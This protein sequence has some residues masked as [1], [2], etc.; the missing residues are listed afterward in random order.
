MLSCE[1]IDLYSHFRMDRKDAAGGRLFC[2]VWHTSDQ[3]SPLGR[4]RP[5]VLILPG[6][7][8]YKVSAREAEPVAMRFLSKGYAAFA[9]DYS[10]APSK[11]PTALREAALAM[12]YIRENAPALEVD[13]HMVSAIGFSAGGHLCGTLG[14]MY[15]CPEVS[16]IAPAQIIRPDALGLCYPVAVSWGNTHEESF[17]NLTGSDAQLRARL[18]LDRLVRPEMPPVFLWHTRTDASVPVRNSLILAQAL[19]EAGVDFAL[20]IFRHGPHG[21]SVAD[22][23]CYPVNRVPDKSADV[24]DWPEKMMQFFREI[25]FTMTDRE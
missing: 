20:H 25:G 7:G 24:T 2:W 11:F 23:Q 22:A 6:G 19:E 5:A 8:Y 3:I 17:L 13:E 16:D 21:I 9:L 18:S 10:I 15:D 1:V 12:R 14:T 4:T